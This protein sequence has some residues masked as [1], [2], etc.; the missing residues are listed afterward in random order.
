MLAE[1]AVEAG[2]G[3]STSAL[4]HGF[5]GSTTAEGT[6]SFCMNIYIYT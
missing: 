2:L 3:R 5:G 1:V 6:L 4:G